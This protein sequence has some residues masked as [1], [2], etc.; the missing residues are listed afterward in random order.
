VKYRMLR[1]G[2]AAVAAAV[3][4]AC[5]GGGGDS[6]PAAAVAQV[7]AAA[8]M[9]GAAAPALTPEAIATQFFNF[10]EHHY[11]DYF[12]ATQPTQVEGA[13]RY[14][15]YPATGIYLG[16]A[17]GVAPG[18]G[19]VENGVYVLGGPFGGPRQVGVLSNFH[20]PV[21][22]PFAS[23]QG[24]VTPAGGGL[25]TPGGEVA[26]AFTSG[27]L[28][29][30]TAIAIT[31]SARTGTFGAAADVTPAIA[32]L[33]TQ[34]SL[35]MKYDGGALPGGWAETAL[36]L[37]RLDGGQ[38][39][40][41]PSSV[42]TAARI[43][44]THLDRLSSA[45]AI[46]IA[47]PQAVTTPSGPY[48]PFSY[49]WLAT[50]GCW[51]SNDM[52]YDWRISQLAQLL[53]Q[54]PGCVTHPYMAA[55]YAAWKPALES[56]PGIDF[57]AEPGVP[58][59]AIADGS[60][61]KAALDVDSGV[62]ELVIRSVVAGSTYRIAYVHCQSHNALTVG[63]AVK[64]GDKVCEAGSVGAPSSHLHLEVKRMGMDENR[65]GAMTAGTT[66]YLKSHTF[67]PAMLVVPS[68]AK[69]WATFRA[70]DPKVPGD[71]AQLPDSPVPYLDFLLS[72]P[73]PLTSGFTVGLWV[74]GE[75]GPSIQ[76]GFASRFPVWDACFTTIG[77]GSSATGA[78][79]VNGVTGSYNT[80]TASGL[81][82]F[83]NPVLK[84]PGCGRTLSVSDFDLT[85]VHEGSLKPIDAVWLAPGQTLP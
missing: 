30:S 9:A 37:A 6:E 72:A 19:L 63:K 47:Q 49:N 35:R 58:V 27:A 82:S 70:G 71:T 50:D 11:A 85:T 18:D 44:S 14:R 12:P 28:E 8:P 26:L 64:A 40:A 45:Y 22:A 48:W 51:K 80:W 7:R 68:L 59:Y 53:F 1:A 5:G 20:T 33:W 2:L 60:V 78:R 23:V 29:Q 81:R 21:N 17:M 56:H 65:L 76:L 43:I 79:K 66:D 73:V 46:R 84:P 62:S 61:E 25:A 36:G 24:T 74:Q 42:D 16:L 13:I 77:G 32:Q 83:L 15:H 38:W 39:V 31:P 34:S 41:L 75:S 55:G 4:A 57:R 52:Q 69:G 67:D 10:A 54:S 3:M